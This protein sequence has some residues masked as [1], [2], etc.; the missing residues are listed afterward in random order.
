MGEEPMYL[1]FTFRVKDNE[2]KGTILGA[3]FK[4]N[5]VGRL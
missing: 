4:K 3:Q 2:L 1:S 5:T